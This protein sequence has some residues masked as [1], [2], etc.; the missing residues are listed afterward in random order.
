MARIVRCFLSTL[1]FKTAM[2]DASLNGDLRLNQ[3]ANISTD[4]SSNGI[5]LPKDY[6]KHS[7]PSKPVKIN[8]TIKIVQVTEIDDVLGTM[9]IQAYLTFKWIDNRLSLHNESSKM[10]NTIDP[11][12]GREIHEEWAEKLWS[13]NI[14]IYDLKEIITPEFNKHYRGKYF[15][16]FS[17]VFAFFGLLA[18]NVIARAYLPKK[19]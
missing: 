14:F 1:F 9:D 16:R 19:H 5:C 2:V 11:S 15:L 4:C 8:V 6:D 7:L 18:S 12:L 17:K 3:E 13:P 10:K